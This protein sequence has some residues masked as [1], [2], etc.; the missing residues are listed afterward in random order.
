M[1]GPKSGHVEV[2][3]ARLAAARRE[4]EQRE[5]EELSLLKR[6]GAQID[7]ANASRLALLQQRAQQRAEREAA[8][9]QALEARLRQ[10][11]LTAHARVVA[12]VEAAIAQRAGLEASHPG[13]SLPLVP[14]VIAE[15]M[16]DSAAV[17]AD[18]AALELQ[19]M[20]Y[21]KAQDNA[22]NQWRQ[23]AA[24]A[25]ASD[26]TRELM[27]RFRANPVRRVEDLIPML[28]QDSAWLHRLGS[29]AKMALLVQQ[30]RADLEAAQGDPQLTP[31]EATAEALE[32]VF[33]STTVSAA[34]TSLARFRVCIESDRKALRA[35]KQIEVERVERER[36]ARE[37]E[38][39]A[40]QAAE[41]RQ[42]VADAFRSVLEDLG[43][44]V[45]DIEG[46]AQ[47]GVSTLLALKDGHPDHAWRID[48]DDAGG[49]RSEAV[50]LVEG[51]PTHAEAA[52][53]PQR[54]AEDHAFDERICSEG[55]QK[56]LETVRE[57]GSGTAAGSARP[58]IKIKLTHRG[59]AGAAPLSVL[60]RELLEPQYR[61]RPRTTAER[62]AL[63][64]R[65]RPP[66]R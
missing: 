24:A 52:A 16:G 12:Q 51:T 7:K 39:Q 62:R 23:H 40:A 3:H 19:L 8:R 9:L 26:D 47:P 33:D 21:R 36:A 54:V 37:A 20:G 17:L 32:A 66:K 50:R 22:I 15:P 13:I 29:Q 5:Q 6:L 49:F 10:R 44:K 63:Q 28:D 59:K 64:T 45:S 14:A 56:V 18:T 31:S 57:R 55:L 65:T 34:Q 27:A 58:A 35:A 42:A 46:V 25:R 4:S 48:F 53:D 1:S 2:D 38:E 41:R 61:R 60:A 30:A 11:A 43:H